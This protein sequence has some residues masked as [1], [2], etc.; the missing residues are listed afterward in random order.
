MEI[1]RKF[2]LSNEFFAYPEK[3]PS[4]FSYPIQQGY[5]ISNDNQEVRIRC[6]NDKDYYITLKTG[7]GIIR[8]EIEYK[9][10]TSTG[11]NVYHDLQSC[12]HKISKTRHVCEGHWEIDIFEG[13][14]EGL[15]MAEIEFFSL[16]AAEALVIPEWLNPYIVREVTEF[17]SCKNKA[18]AT[19]SCISEFMENYLIE[20]NNKML[21]KTL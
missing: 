7:S 18:L 14:I 5:L 20:L 4:M 12:A 11:V 2:L 16:E 1:E 19:M 9:I 3:I 13:C 8:Q 6:K 21:N 15:V 10:D 17:K